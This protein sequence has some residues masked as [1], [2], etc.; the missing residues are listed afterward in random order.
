MQNDCAI[1]TIISFYL[2]ALKNGHVPS[3][4]CFF[5]MIAVKSCLCYSFEI[6]FIM[7]S[8]V[9]ISHF[10]ASTACHLL[11]KEDRSYLDIMSDSLGFSAAATLSVFS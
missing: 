11:I 8:V 4:N 6:R 9:S 7:I 3:Q 10:C 5:L 2:N 1:I